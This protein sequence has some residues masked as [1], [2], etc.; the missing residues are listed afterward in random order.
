LITTNADF[1]FDQG[2]SNLRTSLEFEGE[3]N[4]SKRDRLQAFI[5]EKNVTRTVTITG[6]HSPEGSETI[7]SDLSQDRAKTIEDYY[8][9]QMRRYDYK[10]AADSI[11]F[12]LKP[13]IQDWKAFRAALNAYTG[14]GVD[15][16]DKNEYFKII[17]GTG[18]F[19]EKEKEMQKLSTYKQIFEDIY[20]GLRTAQTEVLTVKPK[21]TNA[22]IAVLS[23]GIVSGQFEADTL[24]EQ[25][26]MFSAT[27]TPS[28]EEK[29]AIYKV[30]ADNYGIWQAHND[31]AATHIE[32]A[33][34]G[35]MSKLD[36]A[37]TQLEIA[38]N[39]NSSSP[40]VQSNMGAVLMLQGNYDEAYEVLSG[41][42]GA[43]NEVNAKVMA[44]KGAVEVRRGEYEKAKT[45][46]NSAMNSDKTNINKGLANIMTNNFSPA[47]SSLKMVGN[48][49]E[50]KALSFYLMAVSAARQG[51]A[52]KVED[53]LKKAV[54]E[55][56]A[57]KDL[58]LND[59]EF[60]NYA[61]AVN[62]AVK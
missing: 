6:T 38:A 36:G 19:V 20:P 7:N 10:G 15:Q 40:A 25:E 53:N 27:L 45:S 54:N 49:S 29:A 22:E 21:K 2:R 4:R 37:Q 1:Y 31:L 8:R 28:L 12:I 16:N 35:D 50:V 59:L 14:A 34:N 55:D 57:F 23:K 33:L 60:S 58:A 3:S 24:N 51:D 18:T 26:M 52:G 13:V 42:S 11:E 44:M 41:I 47:E 32:M 30:V 43:S 46:L 5:A 56:P 39:K 61:D 17:N 48:D 62:N 9:A